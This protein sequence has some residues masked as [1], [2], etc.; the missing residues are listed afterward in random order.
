MIHVSCVHRYGTWTHVS[1][2]LSEHSPSLSYG[3]S[4]CGVAFTFRI[5]PAIKRLTV[6]HNTIRFASG[7]CSRCVRELCARVV[8]ESI[9]FSPAIVMEFLGQIKKC[10]FRVTGLK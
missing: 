1:C 8:C 6:P 5:R 10:V 7:L 4:V 3:T 9:G 2:L